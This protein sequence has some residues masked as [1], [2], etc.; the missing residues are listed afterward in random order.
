[1]SSRTVQ[2]GFRFQRY[3]D[4]RKNARFNDVSR[5][6]SCEDFQVQRHIL[7]K[8]VLDCPTTRGICIRRCPRAIQRPRK[9]TGRLL[10]CDVVHA[11]RTR[12]CPQNVLDPFF[13][14]A[15]GEAHLSTRA[16][17]WSLGAGCRRC[18]Y[19]CCGQR[20]GKTATAT[21]LFS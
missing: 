16:C 17:S 18:A 6:E 1:M 3:F 8:R 11:L 12:A 19:N 14:G 9:L 20:R 21:N 15:C 5:R 2:L 7:R 10:V 13:V 4:K